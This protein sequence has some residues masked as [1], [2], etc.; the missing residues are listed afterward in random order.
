MMSD[1]VDRLGVAS[2][3][4]QLLSKYAAETSPTVRVAI[5]IS[6]NSSI[7]DNMNTHPSLGMNT[8]AG[9][10]ALLGSKPKQNSAVVE[11]V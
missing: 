2:M 5:T 9:S 3:E 8:T 4:Y 1:L 10:L 11:M 7:E 6:A